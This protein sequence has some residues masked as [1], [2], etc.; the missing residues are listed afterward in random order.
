[1]GRILHHRGETK[2]PC[3]SHVF[4]HRH[5]KSLFPWQPNWLSLSQEWRR[6]Q[7]REGRGV[8]VCVAGGGCR[9][10]ARHSMLTSTWPLGENAISVS[11]FPQE[12]IMIGCFS[13]SFFFWLLPSPESSKIYDLLTTKTTQCHESQNLSIWSIMQGYNGKGATK[14]SMPA[15]GRSFTQ[16]VITPHWQR[17]RS[18]CCS[19][20][21]NIFSSTAPSGKMYNQWRL[22]AEKKE[23]SEREMTHSEEMEDAFQKA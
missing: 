9:A 18:K 13:F 4:Q 20:K 17:V 3:P 1:M 22:K 12:N 2:P 7:R 11:W 15:K 23:L 8:C 19:N 5:W 10:G 16:A 21:T 6:R 14:H